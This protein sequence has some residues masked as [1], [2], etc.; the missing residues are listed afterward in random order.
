MNEAVASAVI[1]AID[2]VSHHHAL[3]DKEKKK[4]QFGLRMSLM[5]QRKLFSVLNIEP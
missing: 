4:R 1:G 2:C 5:K 3:A